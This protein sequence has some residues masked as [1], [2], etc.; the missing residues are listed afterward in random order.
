MFIFPKIVKLIRRTLRH[1]RNWRVTSKCGGFR[2]RK[3][4]T[5]RSEE[6]SFT[7]K[8]SNLKNEWTGGAQTHEYTRRSVARYVYLD[9]NIVSCAHRN[10]NAKHLSLGKRA[11]S[12]VSLQ[13]ATIPRLHKAIHQNN[14]GFMYSRLACMQPIVARQG[15]LSY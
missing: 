4:E 1:K 6:G 3:G 14:L 5:E 7:S 10:G 12:K 9:G 13:T 11:C 8:T 15:G 2:L